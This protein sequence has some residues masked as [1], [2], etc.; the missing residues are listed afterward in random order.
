MN[1][2][3]VSDGLNNVIS[4]PYYHSELIEDVFEAYDDK[5]KALKVFEFTTEDN[6]V[7]EMEIDVRYST[8]LHSHTY[9]FSYEI[10]DTED[11]Y[12]QIKA[13]NFYKL[14][15]TVCYLHISSLIELVNKTDDVPLMKVKGIGARDEN[16][17]RLSDYRKEDMAIRLLDR[18]YPVESIFKDSEGDSII[19]LNAELFK[20]LL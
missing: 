10:R 8:E 2:K 17:N 4:K 15:N 12:K 9:D 1:Y 3:S 20:Q 16:G 13:S 11:V 6:T 7:Y 19:K 18:H 5:Y 14:Y